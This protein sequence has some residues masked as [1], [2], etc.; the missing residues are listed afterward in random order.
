[1]RCLYFHLRDGRILPVEV[2]YHR[3]PGVLPELTLAC[4]GIDPA[5]VLADAYIDPTRFRARHAQHRGCSPLHRHGR[6]VCLAA[7]RAGRLARPVPLEAI[8]ALPSYYSHYVHAE[9]PGDPVRITRD[10][11]TVAGFVRLVHEDADQVARDREV[12]R[13]LEH[14]MFEVA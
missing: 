1:M 7:D 12:V 13:A 14:T 4:R 3:L 6:I 8:T 9:K 11:Q 5:E 10:N 2:N